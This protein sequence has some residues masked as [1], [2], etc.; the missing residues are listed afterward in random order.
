MRIWNFWLKSFNL[1][2]S[3][4]IFFNLASFMLLFIVK[5]KDVKN[6]FFSELN[7]T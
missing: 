4:A 5:Q 2:S 3:D 6:V 7:Y 1:N